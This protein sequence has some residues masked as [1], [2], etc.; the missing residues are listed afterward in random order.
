MLLAL[1]WVQISRAPE[2]PFDAAIVSIVNNNH[3]VAPFIKGL[4]WVEPHVQVHFNEFSSSSSLPFSLARAD[5]R[6]L[7]NAQVP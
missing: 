2:L 1:E 7:I 4:L 6:T 3:H 5:A